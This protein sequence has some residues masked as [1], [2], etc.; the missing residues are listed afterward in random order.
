VKQ[1]FSALVALDEPDALRKYAP[2]FEYHLIDLSAYDEAE[3]KGQVFL[4]V[5][6][7]LMKYIFST[8]LAPRL[9]EILALLPLPEQDALEY[10]RTV[11]YYLSEGAKHMTETNFSEALEKAFPGKAEGWMRRLEEKW[12]Q[13]G[14]QEGQQ[15]GMAA[16]TLRLLRRRIGEVDAETQARI[17]ALS[18]E[19]LE[20]LGEALLDFHA[21]DD[22]TAWLH[23]H[24][25]N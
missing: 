1:N 25:T 11:M 14:R 7:L 21:H 18:F 6:L 22:L 13:Q 15:E 24:A 12:I 19:Q 23:K 2:E 8:G 5:G 16:L 3:I 17:R 20:Q 4:R 9:A 10:L